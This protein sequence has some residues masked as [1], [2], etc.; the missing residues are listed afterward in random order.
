LS[1]EVLRRARRAGTTSWSALPVKVWK[2]RR[3]KGDQACNCFRTSSGK[4]VIE[5]ANATANPATH[6]KVSG[7]SLVSTRCGS[8]SRA[9]DDVADS[10]P[11]N[12]GQLQADWVGPRASPVRPCASARRCQSAPR[13]RRQD[14]GFSAAGR[15]TPTRVLSPLPGYEIFTGGRGDL[16]DRNG[17]RCRLPSLP[18]C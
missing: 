5:D 1:H 10:A 7:S 3:G 11:A 14:E 17:T 15:V 12:A 4:V 2:Q 13:A 9:W 6:A 16:E 18:P 8:T